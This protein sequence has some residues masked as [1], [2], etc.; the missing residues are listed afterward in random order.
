VLLLTIPFYSFQVFDRVLASRS[1]NTLLMMTLFAVGAL[2]FVA[3]LN[4][5]RAQ[6]LSRV[7]LWLASHLGGPLFAAGIAGARRGDERGVA[8]LRDLGQ[9]RGFISGPGIAALFE[10]PTVPIFLVATFLI[11]P[12]LGWIASGG[13]LLLVGLALSNSWATRHRLIAAE[14]ATTRALTT[15]SGMMRNADAIEGMGMTPQLRRR[16]EESEAQTW[17]LQAQASDRVSLFAAVT[18]LG[19]LLIQIVTMAGGSYLAIRQEI[20]AG[21]MIAASIIAARGLAPIEA[22]LTSWGSVLAA[23]EAWRRI[24]SLLAAEGTREAPLP[25][26]APTGRLD[27]DRVVFVPGRSPSDPPILKGLSLAIKPGETLGIIGPTA[28]G[29]TT[30]MRL[31]VGCIV[32]TAGHVRLDGADVHAW[33]REDFGRWAGYLPQDVQLLPGTVADNI[34]R[35][36]EPDPTHV[37]AAAMMAGVHDLILSLPAGYETRIGEGGIPLS[38]GQRQ[39]IALARC[40]YRLPR[41]LVLD[42]PNSNLDTEGE[43]ELLQVLDAAKAAKMTVVIVTHRPHILQ[44]VDRIGMIVDGQLSQIGPR[45]EMMARFTRPSVASAGRSAGGER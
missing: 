4:A 42:E 17:R 2:V 35:M 9:L 41:L 15:A 12:T 39:R 13:A 5:L 24:R 7:S 1:E 20:T 21:M 34:A 31:L 27:V 22:A 33:R 29:K 11:H 6:L 38:G 44:R 26:P 30:L 45:D 25:L 10:L 3:L 19:R 40:V 23:R 28:S 32:P 36:G 8:A 18:K 43:E 37:V 16:W 14:Q